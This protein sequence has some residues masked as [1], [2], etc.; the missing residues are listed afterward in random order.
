MN[1]IFVPAAVA[2]LICRFMGKKQPVWLLAVGWVFGVFQVGHLAAMVRDE[3]TSWSGDGASAIV[4]AGQVGSFVA[5]LIW[6]YFFLRQPKGEQE[7]TA[8]T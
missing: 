1:P 8:K 6:L 7:P 5:G 4:A 3:L 2:L